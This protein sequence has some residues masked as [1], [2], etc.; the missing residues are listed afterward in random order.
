MYPALIAYAELKGTDLPVLVEVADTTLSFDLKIT[1]PLYAS[2]D[3]R[4]Y[5]VIDANAL[6]THVHRDPVDRQYRSIVQLQHDQLL[7]P[8]LAPDLAVRLADLKLGWE[9]E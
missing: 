9:Q 6:T 3:V 8:H 5:W 2:Y 1:G 7:I 4:E